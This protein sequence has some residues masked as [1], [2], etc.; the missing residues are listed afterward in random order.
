M[1]LILHRLD[2]PLGQLLLVTDHQQLVRALDFSDYSERMQRLLQ[3]HYG[4]YTLTAATGACDSAAPLRRYFSGDLDALNQVQVATNGS[5]FQQQVWASLRT[6][7]HGTTTSYS[8]LA[9]RLG[10]NGHA[11]ARAVGSANGANPIAII[12]PCHRVVGK[13]GDLRGFAGG[14]HRK[15]WLLGHERSLQ[16]PEAPQYSLTF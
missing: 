11:A 12:V 8:A 9:S 2:S 5:A 13:N 6:I 10:L 4:E 7:P 1:K 16:N 15:Q 14:L 3:R